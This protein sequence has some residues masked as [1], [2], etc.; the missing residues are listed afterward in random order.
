MLLLCVGCGGGVPQ[1]SPNVLLLLVDD[2]NDWVGGLGRRPDV[3]TPNIDALAARGTLFTNAYTAS[4]KCNPSR[5][6]LLTGQRPTTTGIYDNQHW[7]RPHLPDVVT[8]PEAFR[9][10]GYRAAGG[11]KIFHHTA[12][13]N[14]PDQW[15]EYFELPFDDPW[16]RG[17]KSAYP[18]EP[19]TP[20]PDWHPLNGITPFSHELDWGSPAIEERDYGDART[21]AWASELLARD[22]EQPFFLAVGLFHPHLPWYAPEEQFALHPPQEAVAPQVRDDDL[23]D[24]PAEGRRLAAAGGDTFQTIQEHGQWQQAVAAY[25]ANISYADRLVG[26][27]IEALDGSG[28]ADDTVIVFASDHGFHLGEK[29]HWYKS[30]LWERSTHVPLAIVAPG[31]T[32]AGAVREQA[33]SLID[34][35]P[36]LLELA[37]APPRGDLDG[38]SLKPLLTDPNEAEK[39]ALITFLRGNHAVRSGDWLYVR[40]RDG[41]EELYD[42][43]GDP[44]EYINLAG[45]PRYAALKQRL[46]AAIPSDEAEQAPA[47]GEY[48]FDPQSYRWTRLQQR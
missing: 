34:I 32:E 47:K 37:G 35:Y 10:A 24:V 4:P 18:L 40:Y 42:R 13:F 1:R 12:G 44:D 7:W 6:A 9:A 5:T 28:H 20:F 46:A 25:L 8:L 38:V 3:K 22:D 27:L 39:P 26:R 15:D 17:G 2:M 45:D 36:T 41:G 31:V 11:G 30:T 21:V 29:N 48:D 43:S 23:D 19:L 33:V 14:P 16:D